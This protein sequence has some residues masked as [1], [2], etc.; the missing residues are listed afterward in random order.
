MHV[1]KNGNQLKVLENFDEA[2]NLIKS[3]HEDGHRGRKAVTAKI[4]SQYFFRGGIDR[5]VMA[6]VI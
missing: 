1:N 6:V 5:I 3:I 4:K 2:V